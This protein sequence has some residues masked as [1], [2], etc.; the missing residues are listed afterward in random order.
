MEVP[1]T[2]TVVETGSF[3]R[4]NAGEREYVRRMKKRERSGVMRIL[5]ADSRCNGLNGTPL[6]IQVLQSRVPE[7]MKMQIFEDLRSCVSEKYVGW[8]RRVVALPLGVVHT[9]HYMRNIVSPGQKVREARHIM[10]AVVDGH[11]EIK[12]EVSKLICQAVQGGTLQGGYSIGLEGPPGTGKT[13]FVRNALARALDRP[14]VSFQLGGA[15]DVSYLMGQM[16]TYEGSKEGRL[17]SALIETGV[18]NPI[19]YFD[20]VDK[21]SE[22]ERGR[23]LTAVLIHLI[24]PTSN[25]AM[26]DRYFHGIDLDFSKCLFVFSYNDPARVN[27]V[28]LDR[29][30][31]IRVQAPTTEERCAILNKYIVPRVAKRLST[32]ANIEKEALEYIVKRGDAKNEGMRGCEKDI[33]DVM[34]QA[35]LNAAMNEIADVVVTAADAKRWCKQNETGSRAPHHMYT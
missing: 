4:L 26:R 5:D 22:T 9:P 21:I 2:T 11:E 7:K 13:H 3:A 30:K 8:V 34:A 25:S 35:Q 20:E 1:V 18:S 32:K 17:A 24:D 12:N 31:R 33:D 19:M 10:D 27:P 29:I 14:M 6:R 15:S 16:Y 28:L 23:E